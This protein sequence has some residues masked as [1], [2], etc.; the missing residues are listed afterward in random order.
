[1][2]DKKICPFPKIV[3][4][5][6]MGTRPVKPQSMYKCDA[7]K[8]DLASSSFGYDKEILNRCATA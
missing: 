8:A 1:M 3:D 2:F 7:R 4:A 5:N 6:E